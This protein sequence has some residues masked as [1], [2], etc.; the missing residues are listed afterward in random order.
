MCGYKMKPTNTRE[1]YSWK[2]ILA[3]TVVNIRFV[4]FEPMHII[5]ICILHHNYTYGHSIIATFSPA[6]PI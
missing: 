4:G 3:K 2:C 5:Q 6:L 1:E